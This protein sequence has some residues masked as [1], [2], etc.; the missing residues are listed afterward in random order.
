MSNVIM[1]KWINVCEIL[2]QYLQ[3]PVEMHAITERGQQMAAFLHANSYWSL[4]TKVLKNANM[5]K[6]IL[7]SILVFYALVTQKQFCLL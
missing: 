5:K 2:W 6:L 7:V 1:L 4:L 3:T